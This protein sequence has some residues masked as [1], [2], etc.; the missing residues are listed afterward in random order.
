MA[1]PTQEQHALARRIWERHVNGEVR[2]FIA[3]L[4][5]A[6]IERILIVDVEVRYENGDRHSGKVSV[7]DNDEYVLF[8]TGMHT[9]VLNEKRELC[10]E[11]RGYVRD[12]E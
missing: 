12:L 1:A 4:H 10:H 9:R 5:P 8:V 3:A 6:S 7:F 2:T 11:M